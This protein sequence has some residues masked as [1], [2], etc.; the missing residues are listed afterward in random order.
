MSFLPRS[1]PICL[2][3]TY[4]KMSS[5]NLTEYTDKEL[6]TIYENLQKQ[7]ARVGTEIKRRKA[8]KAKAA[9]LADEPASPGVLASLLNL[10]TGAEEK[11]AKATATRVTIKAKAAKAT[12]SSSDDEEEKKPVRVT[13]AH[14]KAAYKKKTGDNPP[15]G[16]SKEDLEEEVRKVGALRMAAE[17]A[18]KA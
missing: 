14:L 3:S 1:L 11:P 13:M 18:R 6:L 4:V 8:K 16:L 5:T 10:V 9:A 12:A 2:T 7:M 17:I 15:S